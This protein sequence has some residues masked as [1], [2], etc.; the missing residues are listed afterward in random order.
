MR[1]PWKHIS[2][3][4]FDKDKHEVERVLA[5]YGKDALV[6]VRYMAECRGISVLEPGLQQETRMLNYLGLTGAFML[7]GLLMSGYA[8]IGKRIRPV[9]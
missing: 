5:R 1:H 9:P 8:F 4:Y 7:T 3:R 2:L 6:K